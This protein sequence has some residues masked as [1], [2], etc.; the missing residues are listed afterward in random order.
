MKLIK[1]M[2]G[3]LLALTL[4]FQAVYAKDL[5][6]SDSVL[7]NDDFSSDTLGDYINS[8][9]M[10]NSGAL[11]VSGGANSGRLIKQ[12]GTALSSGAYSISATFNF[13][14]VANVKV[15]LSTS[16][17]VPDYLYRL[18][19]SNE[20]MQIADLDICEISANKDYN[21]E[22]RFSLDTN[23]MTVYV[24]GIRYLEDKALTINPLTDAN[25][26]FEIDARN[27]SAV[28]NVDNIKFKKIIWDSRENATVV[29]KDDFEISKSGYLANTGE[30]AE[31]NGS[32]V[33]KIVKGQRLLAGATTITSGAVDISCDVTIPES[34]NA[35]GIMFGMTDNNSS[36]YA[37]HTQLYGKDI[38][39]TGVK[40]NGEQQD[41]LICKGVTPGK[42]VNLRFVVNIDRKTVDAYVDGKLFKNSDGAQMYIQTLSNYNRYFDARSSVDFYLDNLKVT[43]YAGNKFNYGAY[44][45]YFDGETSAVFDSACTDGVMTV[46]PGDRKL[47]ALYGTDVPTSGI[48][49]ASFDIKFLSLASNGAFDDIM[50]AQSVTGTVNTYIFDLYERNGD[51]YLRS[52]LDG[53]KTPVRFR[54]LADADTKESFNF[55]YTVNLDTKRIYFFANGEQVLPEYKLYMNKDA[56]DNL[57]RPADFNMKLN[58]SKNTFTVDNYKFYRDELGALLEYGGIHSADIALPSTVDGSDVTYTSDDSAAVSN[59][60]TVNMPE[61]EK[62]V[63]LTAAAGGHKLPIKITVPGTSSN[64]SLSSGNGVSRAY[65][66]DLKDGIIILCT[67]NSDG[68]LIDITSSDAASFIT[69]EHINSANGDYTV[70]AMLWDGFTEIKPLEKSVSNALNIAD[71]EITVR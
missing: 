55:K 39:M 38:Y 19:I 23:E 36:K 68:E 10:Y 17:T 69:A 65:A 29:W 33:Y 32:K 37:F 6:V 30:I 22:V 28:F 51:I 7:I 43:K 53:G 50:S 49:S 40:S 4:V 63:T 54:I 41:F 66:R 21:V 71:G 2:F 67:Y 3:L 24:N 27:S 57:A 11:T 16:N 56:R 42:F 46:A 20:K 34:G 47:H 48:Y 58:N 25:R 15:L 5:S 59:T 61:A 64:V 60:G 14:T 26:L 62:T 35:G 9:V 13:N 12:T 52:Y 18:S 44:Y 31:L 70:K 8:G 1:K 45:D